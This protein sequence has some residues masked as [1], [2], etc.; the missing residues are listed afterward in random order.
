MAF[1]PITME[2]VRERGW[3]QVDFVLVTG[4]AYVDHNTFG[5][6]IISR[7]LEDAGYRVAILAQPDWKTDRDFQRFGRPRLGFMCNSGNLDSMVAHYTT[8]RKRRSDDAYSPGK[9]P[10]RRPDRAVIVYSK[11]L[12]RLYPDVPVVIGGLEASLRRF[13][14]Y[15]YWENKIRPSILLDSGADLL[16]FGMGE[17]QTLE[18]AR[19]L[20]AGESVK[21]MTDIRGTC[22]VVPS[23]EYQPGPAVD[24]PSFEQVCASKREY[25]VS[26]RKQQDEQDAVRG[27]RVIQRHGH[28]I[29]VQNPPAM[30]L[31]Q[32]ELDHVFELPYEGTYHP[33]YEAEGGV[34]AIEEVEFSITHNRGCFGA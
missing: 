21:T 28:Q 11:I 23:N 34:P 19:R 27:K 22:Y 32:E 2:E 12:K 29:V 14:H 16:S 8:A 13:A 17:R 33:V 18:I 5:T 9:K 31:T 30:P 26:C 6:A 24:C 4:D 20:D 3:D 25:A 7:V 10:G 1:L 15:D